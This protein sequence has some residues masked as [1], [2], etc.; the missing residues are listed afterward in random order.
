MPKLQSENTSSHKR[1][2]DSLD[3]LSSSAVGIIQDKAKP[4]ISCY[5]ILQGGHQRL[6]GHI[7]RAQE[8]T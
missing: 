4:R 5:T 8:H 3:S 7:K 2:Q 6:Q 1:K